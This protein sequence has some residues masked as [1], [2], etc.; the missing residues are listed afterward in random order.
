MSKGEVQ[1]PK[2]LCQYCMRYDCQAK[3]GSVVA[4][5]VDRDEAPTEETRR[6]TQEHMKKVLDEEYEPAFTVEVN[7]R[8]ETWYRRKK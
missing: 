8:K 4:C 1:Y 5:P 3:G 6:A 7:G 2:L